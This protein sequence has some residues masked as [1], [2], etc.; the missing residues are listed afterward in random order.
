MPDIFQTRLTRENPLTDLTLSLPHSHSFVKKSKTS[1]HFKKEEKTYLFFLQRPFSFS[2]SFDFFLFL[3]LSFI[4]L[5]EESLYI[6]LFVLLLVLECFIVLIKDISQKNIPLLRPV[7]P[8]FYRWLSLGFYRSD[9]ISTF[10]VLL[11]SD[12]FYLPAFDLHFWSASIFFFS[13]C[14]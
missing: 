11:F 5:E 8:S 12:S 2:F 3:T 13:Y 14:F 6:L 7:S 4:P 9:I 10:S 1:F